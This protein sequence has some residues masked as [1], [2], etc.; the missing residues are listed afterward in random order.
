MKAMDGYGNGIMLP[1]GQD[2]PK[3]PFAGQVMS[4]RVRFTTDSPASLSMVRAP[5]PPAPHSPTYT[6][7]PQPGS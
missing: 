1:A 2:G 3:M 4:F 6:H 5:P 7:A